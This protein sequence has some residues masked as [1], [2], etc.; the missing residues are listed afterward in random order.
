M[1]AVFFVSTKKIARSGAK[2]YFCNDMS[3]KELLN[4]LDAVCMGQD[5][6][7]DDLKGKGKVEVY[8]RLLDAKDAIE[9][10]MKTLKPQILSEDDSNVENWGLKVVPSYDYCYDNCKVIVNDRK[11]VDKATK[12]LDK[13]MRLPEIVELQKTIKDAQRSID[14]NPKVIEAKGALSAAQTTLDGHMKNAEME[15]KKAYEGKDYD[16]T[17]DGVTRS[18]KSQAIRRAKK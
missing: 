8:V 16:H 14:K 13:T 1:A 12:A 6:A 11:A 10:M 9:E 2:L 3:K 7:F 18:V 5:L 17:Y 15:A 4:G